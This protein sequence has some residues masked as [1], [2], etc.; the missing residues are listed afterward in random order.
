MKIILP[1]L[2]LMVTSCHSASDRGENP[3]EVG[4]VKWLRDHAAALAQ[5]KASGKPVF[6]LFQE[7]PG[8]AGCKQFGKDVLSDP[9]VVKSIEENFVPLLIP[10]NQ[11][12]KDREILNQYNEP[13]W[14]YQVVRFLDAEGK[15]LI[16]RKDKVWTAE[17]LNQR[18]DAVL[19]KK[20]KP[21]D[22]VAAPKTGRLAISQSCFWTGEMKIGAIEGVTRT[23][24]GFFDGQEVTMVDYDPAKTSPAKIYEQAKL[25]GVGIGAYLED[26]SQLP[27]S[28]KLSA[29]YRPASTGDQKKQIQGTAFQ[30]LDLTSEQATKVN[31]FARTNLSHAMSY[32]TESQ[33]KELSK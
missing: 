7:V 4:T 21:K 26:P 8:C 28:K 9:A 11:D 2:Y 19:G 10:N 31:A 3:V 30:K 16:P 29:A 13:A 23:E 22:A 17:E 32:L 14:N 25:D 1:L 15:D 24:A 12:G 20:G 27:G 18:I 6:L 5:S 33:N